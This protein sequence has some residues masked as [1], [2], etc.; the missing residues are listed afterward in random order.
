MKE[1]YAVLLAGWFFSAA[2]L[3]GVCQA[4]AANYGNGTLAAEASAED[5]L[6]GMSDGMPPEPPADGKGPGPGGQGQ[7]AGSANALKAACIV[8]KSS[9]NLQGQKLTTVKADENALLVRNGGSLVLQDAVLQKTGDSTSV[10]DSNFSGSNAIVLSNNSTIKLHQVELSSAAEG[11]N[12]IFSTGKKSQIIADHVK[13]YTT[14][15]SSR[16]LDATYG[17]TITASDVDIVT[18]GAHCAALAT[19]RGEGT[20]TVTRGTLMTSGEGSPC[21]YS[22]GA[23]RAVDSRGIASNSEIAVVEGKNSIELQNAE[24]T[25]SVKHGIMLYQSFSGDAGTGIASF[26]SVGSKLTN[27]ST[28]PMFYVT[29]TKAQAQLEN[30]QLSSR[31]TVLIDVTSGQWGRKGANGGDF[32]LTAKNQTLQGAVQANNLS[33]VKLVLENGSR[34]EGSLDAANTARQADISLTAGASWTMTADSH[35]DSLEDGQ[36]DFANIQSNGHTLYYNAQKSS[37][38]AGKTYT[39][40]GGGQLRPEK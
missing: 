21:V 32:V 20:V 1:K 14:A 39:L 7:E 17:G 23:I 13:I 35:V 5:M 16:G 26:K 38:L 36:Q 30:N 34:W 31:G 24:L 19:D 29:N 6:P 27:L 33:Q 37:Q 4:G 28:G 3:S 18:E 22:T 8:D 25:G 11:A 12:A 15:G 2:C 9:K 40:A 10:D